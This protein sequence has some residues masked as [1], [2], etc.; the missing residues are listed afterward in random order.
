MEWGREVCCRAKRKWVWVISGQFK[1]LKQLKAG[2]LHIHSEGKLIKNQRDRRLRTLCCTPFVR[3][4]PFSSNFLT[5]P[6]VSC[7]VQGKTWLPTGARAYR[8]WYCNGEGTK[9]W[10]GHT[11]PRVPPSLFHPGVHQVFRII[12]LV[13]LPVKWQQQMDCIHRAYVDFH[14]VVDLINSNNIHLLKG[15]WMCLLSVHHGIILNKRC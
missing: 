2:I 8:Y 11:A 3:D 10:R 1:R 4:S 15:S 7:P 9:G 6:W 14:T 5:V 13:N 12:S